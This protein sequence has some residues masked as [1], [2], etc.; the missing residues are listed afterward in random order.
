MYEL[1]TMLPTE[2][3]E[4]EPFYILSY[5]DDCLACGDE[6]QTKELY[7]KAFNFDA[8][9]KEGKRMRK[10]L[11]DTAYD[12]LISG[13]VDKTIKNKKEIEEIFINEGIPLSHKMI[14]FQ[15]LYG[16]ISY[17]IGTEFYEG[18]KMDIFSFC[19]DDEKYRL[20]YYENRDG[21]Y[22]LNCMDYHYAGDI[23]PCIDEDGKIYRFAMGN[24]SICA[25]NIEEFLE[26]EAVKYYFV[27]KHSTWLKRGA[28]KS[29]VHEFIKAEN[30]SK[31]EKKSFSNKYFEWWYNTDE[32]IFI[33]INLT[34][35]VEQAYGIIYC[36]NQKVL[37][38]LY[39]T[40]MAAMVYPSK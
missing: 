17:K 12:M 35:N 20:N 19:D 14:E 31:I 8:Y 29:E 25:D 13:R 6:E 10:N 4:E 16:G 21:K 23:G 24:F 11:S 36:K 40:N 32:T 5:A 27:K 3:N 39:K 33:R 22:Y 18:F 15:L 28:K 30:L 9:K 2:I 34:T 37:D 1:W 26:D 38:G 7:E